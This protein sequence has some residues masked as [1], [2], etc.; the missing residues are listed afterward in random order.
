[1]FRNLIS[2]VLLLAVSSVFAGDVEKA[3]KYLNNGE[4]PNAIKY[5]REAQAD[6]PENAAVNY[7]LSKYFSLH[8][9]AAFH[10][11]SANKYILL[12]AK[13]IP[14]NPD[15]KETKKLANLGVRDYT[16][17]TL[18]KSINFEAYQQA[19]KENSLESYQHFLDLYT[20]VPL[21]EQATNFR[22][23]KAYM[24]AMS[25]KTPEAIAE[26]IKKYPDAAELKEAKERYEKMLYDLTTADGTFQSFKKYL[27]NYPKGAYVD[28]AKKIYNEKVLQY[29]TSQ[30]SLNAYLEFERNYKDHPA[31][32]NILDSIYKLATAD[33][34]VESFKNFIANY[35][36]NPHWNDAWKQLYILYTAA[37]TQ[38][39]YLKFSQNFPEYP[40]K[41]EVNN[42]LQLA[43]RDLKPFQ[44]GEKWG[45]MEQPAP[46]SVQIVVSAEYVEAYDFKCGYAAVSSKPCTDVKCFYYYINKAN[47][48]AFEGEFN[49]A[50]DFENGVAVVGFGDCEN[51]DCKYGLIDKRGKFVIPAD[52]DELDGPYEDLFIAEKDGK[53]G[54]IN[55]KN[56]VVISLKYSDVVPFREDIA[57]V[58]I[59]GNWFFIDKTGQQ[60]FINR[61]MN[62][63]S[64]SEG[65]CAVTS[66]GISWG[67]IDITGN[68]VIEPAFETADDFKNAVAIV[69]KKEKDPK[70]KSLFI[71][72]RYK[73]DMTGK[74]LEKLTAPK[75]TVAKKNTKK[76]RS[77]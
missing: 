41:D 20:D 49:Y 72:Q 3:F 6:E 31:Y 35:K 34:T 42:D 75:E 46:D 60:K 53:Y 59:S 18:Q 32:K 68:Y 13:K 57:A 23:Q 45:Y 40:F 4:Y 11:D 69:S 39:D 12:A 54:F 27:D 30:N 74:V 66:D 21:R 24:R 2:G 5:L 37:G 55:R 64:F 70:N 1:M 51:G 56:E 33:G 43:G 38:N 22:N 63:S 58:S 77:K 47:K 19:E 14:L 17:Q 71:S 61:F 52:Y 29:Y 36:G 48:R 65:L 26:F 10:L 8:D 62:V 50:G 28:E 76:K 67:Y 15:D 9:N 44:Q 7:G 16:I 25:L 73:I